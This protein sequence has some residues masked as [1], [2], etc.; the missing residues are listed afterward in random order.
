MRFF[1]LHCDTLYKALIENSSIYKNNYQLSVKRG[2]RFSPWFQCFAIW[3][4]D[5]IRGQ[6]AL[7]L[8]ISAH[9][10]LE[11]EIQ[12][13]SDEMI[14]C[15][16]TEEF[17]SFINE[18]TCN[19]IFTIEGGAALA[20]DLE[21][22]DLFKEMGVKVITLTWNNSCEIGDG[23]GVLESKGLTA[24]GRSTIEKMEKLG[25]IVDVSHS[26]DKLF[27]DVASVATKPIIATHSNSRSICN[28]KR[29][30]T[31]E[32]FKVIKDMGGIVGINFSSSFLNNNAHQASIKD[33]LSHTEYF[34]SLG[35]EKV[36][37]MGSDFDG[38]DMPGDIKGIESIEDIA[39]CFL[40][41]NYSEQLV[42]DI[43]FKNAYDFFTR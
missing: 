38:T 21:N 23:V 16:T 35:G 17:P 22:L 11:K 34:L 19:V 8:V 24:F 26:S 28:H 15:K 29:N 30:L 41:H 1:D 25:I 42:N 7:D 14:Q 5:E 36:V 39:E 32:Q 10:L 33:I 13:H 4:P 27:F 12:L 43:L 3:I 2:A 40:S 20:G 9:K 31:D 37:A 18:K 6:K